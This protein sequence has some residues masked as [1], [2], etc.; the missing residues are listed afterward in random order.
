MTQERRIGTA[1]ITERPRFNLFGFFFSFVLSPRQQTTVSYE[2]MYEA[3]SGGA[4]SSIRV[5]IE[6]NKSDPLTRHEGST[7]GKKM[8]F[9]PRSPLIEGAVTWSGH[10]DSSETRDTTR[11][12]VERADKPE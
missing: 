2:W 7:G 12:Q 5:E 8:E 6:T 11:R 10:G 1:R 4:P 9:R 3:P